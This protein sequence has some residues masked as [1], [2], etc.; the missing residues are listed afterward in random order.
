MLSMGSA[1]AESGRKE[2]DIFFVSRI[3]LSQNSKT[4][5]DG[6]KDETFWEIAIT[7]ISGKGDR[8]GTFLEVAIKT[9]LFARRRHIQSHIF[10]P[11]LFIGFS[12]YPP[13]FAARLSSRE[14]WRRRR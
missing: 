6:E 10:Y 5:F 3:F 9:L 11:F 13:F 8:N 2:K 7:F 12:P 4:L 14:G 1:F